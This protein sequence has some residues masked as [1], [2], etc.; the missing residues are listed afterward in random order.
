MLDPG[1]QERSVFFLSHAPL[2]RLH[3]ARLVTATAKL[4]LLSPPRALFAYF[5]LPLS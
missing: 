5:V 3:V 1:E 4:R 2:N